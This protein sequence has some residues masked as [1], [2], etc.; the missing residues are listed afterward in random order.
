MVL[1]AWWLHCARLLRCNLT[2][3][4]IKADDK[5]MDQCSFL[6]NARSKWSSPRQLAS[7]TDLEK[8]LDQFVPFLIRADRWALTSFVILL[9]N[10]RSVWIAGLGGLTPLF[11]FLTLPVICPSHTPGGSSQ[12]PQLTMFTSYRCYASFSVNPEYSSHSCRNLA[13]L[14]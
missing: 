2:L 6:E 3:E 10:V 13:R 14:T 5:I 9:A 8:I 7:L 4:G 1:S 12:T 11:I